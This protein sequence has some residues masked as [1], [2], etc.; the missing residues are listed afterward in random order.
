MNRHFEYLAVWHN[1]KNNLTEIA[2]RPAKFDLSEPITLSRIGENGWELVS[3][4]LVEDVVDGSKLKFY[5]IF[6]REV[7]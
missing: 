4:S 5:L 6:K 7:K 2:Y 1:H 3:S